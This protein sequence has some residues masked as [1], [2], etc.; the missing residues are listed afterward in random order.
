M[1]INIIFSSQVFVARPPSA[2]RALELLREYQSCKD[3]KNVQHISKKIDYS[4]EELSRL[5]ER[6]KRVVAVKLVHCETPERL[7]TE[8]MRKTQ[9]RIWRFRNN[10]H[11]FWAD[12]CGLPMTVLREISALC[13]LKHSNFVRF[14]DI[15]RGKSPQ[16]NWQSENLVDLYLVMEYAHYGLD[17]VFKNLKYKYKQLC[18]INNIGQSGQS[19]FIS[20]KGILNYINNIYK[21]HIQKYKESRTYIEEYGKSKEPKD[22]SFSS[23]HLKTE[24]IKN[25]NMPPPPRLVNENDFNFAWY[26]E[27]LQIGMFVCLLVGYFLFL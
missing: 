5:K 17:G 27:H 1:N 6:S 14:L 2:V 4:S 3:N 18:D 13:E 26:R 25:Y 7:R 20:S 10:S 11:C 21:E 9:E 24:Y 23:L 12:P 8:E 19:I 22:V 16:Q 15:I